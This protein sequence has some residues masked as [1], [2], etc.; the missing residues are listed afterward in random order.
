MMTLIDQAIEFAAKAHRGQKRKGTKIPYISHPFAVGMILQQAG[1]E[2]EVVIAGIL[3]DTLEDTKATEEELLALF[4][5]AVLDIVKGC[6]EPDKGASW[7]ERKQHTLDFLKDAPLTIRLVACADKLHNIRSI[8]SDLA[9]LGEEAWTRFKRG[10]ESQR[11]YYTG[12]VESLGYTERFALLDQLHD[13]VEAVFCQKLDNP[14]WQNLRRNKKFFD[15]AYKTAYRDPAKLVKLEPQ[16]EQLGALEIMQLTH[17]LAYPIH[18]DYVQGYDELIIYL[19][20]RGIEMPASNGESVSLI[21]FSAVLMQLLNLYPHE[22]F[23]HIKRI[24][25]HRKLS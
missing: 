21:G 6:S 17:S 10:S 14:N 22:I 20:E 19:Q 4:G 13:E 23:H 18:T 3:H 16:L 25:K 9:K 8:K 11:W 1:C 2:E 24:L 15:L 7:E 5:A 12:L